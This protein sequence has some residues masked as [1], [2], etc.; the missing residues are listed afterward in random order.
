MSRVG[1]P[2]QLYSG[3]AWTHD[4]AGCNRFPGELAPHT[5]INRMQNCLASGA[6]FAQFW[7]SSGAHPNATGT[8]GTPYTATSR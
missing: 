4:K 5:S 6:L 7:K 8:A 2:G 3:R 1:M